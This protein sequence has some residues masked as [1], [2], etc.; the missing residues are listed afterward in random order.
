VV[1]TDTRESCPVGTVL[2]PE[3]GECDP[4]DDTIECA[5]GFHLENGLCVADDDTDTDT[6]TD[7]PTGYVRNLATGACEKVEDKSCPVGQVRNADGKCVPITTTPPP[8]GCPPGQTKNAAGVCV[9]IKTVL[10]DIPTG[11]LS[12]MSALGTGEK[13]DPIYASGVDDFN[14]FATLEELLSNNPDKKSKDKTKM[15][16]GGY[17]DDLLAEQMTVDDLLKLLR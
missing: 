6:N 14:L 10:P 2:N 4:I 13:I 5:P 12:S 15:A 9:P 3:T 16:T 7:C 17:L 1:I 11:F 8:A